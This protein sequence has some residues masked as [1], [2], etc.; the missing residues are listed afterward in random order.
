MDKKVWILAIL[1]VAMAFA[2][3]PQ[4]AQAAAGYRLVAGQ[5]TIVGWVFVDNDATNLTVTFQTKYSLGYCIN[6]T[7]LHVA[8]ELNGIPVNGG[9]NPQVGQF[10][11]KGEHNCVDKVTYVIPLADLPANDGELTLAAHAVIGSWNEAQLPGYE[12]TGWG[13][14]CGNVDNPDFQFPGGNWAMFTEYPLK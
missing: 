2:L 10:D 5:N 12:E 9:G 11:Y 8:D 7:Q 1:I 4:Q 6:E 3:S 14:I 13:V